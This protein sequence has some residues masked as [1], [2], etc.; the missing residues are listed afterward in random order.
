MI[1]DSCEA[2]RG[3]S[4]DVRLRA[5][6]VVVFGAEVWWLSKLPGLLLRNLS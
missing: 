4:R 1:L 3:G 2:P 6:G 5:S